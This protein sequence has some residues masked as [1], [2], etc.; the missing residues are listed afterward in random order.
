VTYTLVDD[1]ISYIDSTYRSTMTTMIEG[2][3]LAVIVV[4]IFLRDWRAT[5]TAAATIPLSIIPTFWAMSVM[6]FSLNPVSLLAMTLV[7]G[8]LVDDAIVEIENIVRHMRMGKSPYRAAMEASDEIGLA[9]IAI[10]LT[11][12]AVFAPVSFMGGI[13]GQYFKQFGLTV[14]VA[15]LFSLLVARLVT[16]LMAAYCMSPH[17][18]WEARDGLLMRS[19]TEFLRV[20]VR[21]RYLTLAAGL[22]LFAISIWSTSL[23]PTG[24]MPVEDIS[25]TVISLE[26]PPGSTLNA[27]RVETD[28]IAEMLRKVP[29][30]RSVVTL[31]GMTPTGQSSEVRKAT[32]NVMLTPKGKRERSQKEVEAE[33]SG[34]LAEV[35]DIRT[36]YVNPRGERELAIAIMSKDPRALD[37]GVTALEVAMRREH[38]FRNVAANAGLDQPEVRVLPRLDEAARLGIS[39]ETISETVRVATIGDVGPALAKFN[40]GDRQIPIRVQLKE[41]ARRD[42]RIIETLAVP[43]TS[44]VTVPLSGVA[45]VAFGQGPSSIERYDRMRRVVIG[46]DL[47]SGMT[48]GQAFD[49]VKSLPEAQDLPAGVWIQESGDAEIMVEAFGSFANAMGAGLLMMLA[50]LILLFGSVFQPIT[51]LFSL[52]LSIGGAILALLLTGNPISLPVVIGILM[53]MGIVTKNAIM[54]VDFAAEEERRGVPRREAIVDAGRKRV[55]PIIM[56]TIAMV[57]GMLPS[58]LA[59]GDGSE[60]Q[61]PM[62]IAVIGGL[63]VST[64]LSLVFVPSF[65]VVAEGFSDRAQRF[66]GRFIGPREKHIPADGKSVGTTTPDNA[67]LVHGD[68]DVGIADGGRS[69]GPA[70]PLLARTGQ[71]RACEG[72]VYRLQAKQP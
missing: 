54:L 35:P 7:T 43:G 55:R 60:F 41:A 51:I 48:L 8:I 65:Y 36:W 45:N 70:S 24:F 66:F 47:I 28:R 44:G 29:E 11:I 23:L 69:G 12:V 20:S 39:T 9:V 32:L 3:V 40:A 38:G 6:G 17:A 37:A 34:R 53:L 14:T 30:V 18:A 50:V 31:G 27:T 49:Q 63:I 72:T 71:H 2:A 19:Y 33:I 4:L 42:L 22:A 67:A 57:A 61:A 52:P 58:T 68:D 26:L 62:A 16:P 10:T 64:V 56:T 59:T 13:A 15:V 25:R 46:A 5:L 1:T 21:H